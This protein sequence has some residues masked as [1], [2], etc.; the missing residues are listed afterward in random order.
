MVKI[1]LERKGRKKKPF[2]RMVVIDIRARRSGD[3]IEELG[4]YNP[5]AKQL[6]I[7][8]NKALEWIAKG[9]QPSETAL[10]LINKADGTGELMQLE[11][12]RAERLSKKAKARIADEEKA[13]ADAVAAEAAAKEA[14]KAEAEAA[15]AAAEAPAAEEPAAAEEAPA[16]APA[17][18]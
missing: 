11:I 15:K 5:I 17:A 1:R 4:F 16:E 8:K 13:K 18:E 12:K 10:R 9:A 7:D 3:P 14:A 6:K 2:Y